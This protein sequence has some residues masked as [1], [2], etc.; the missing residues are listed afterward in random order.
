MANKALVLVSKANFQSRDKQGRLVI[1][2][3]DHV[4]HYLTRSKE[5]TVDV[6]S[7]IESPRL[8]KGNA[9]QSNEKHRRLF[10]LLFLALSFVGFALRASNIGE[11]SI[12]RHLKMAWLH[13]RTTF[14]R[15]VFC[16][17]NPSFLLGIGLSD[18]EL[19]A[20]RELGIRSFEIQHGDFT[21][22]DLDAY[23][24]NHCPDFFLLWGEGNLDIVE[25]FG[26]TPVLIPAP[27]SE[28]IDRSSFEADVLVPLTHS[29]NS[30]Q[31]G[32]IETISK[33]LHRQLEALVNMGL[34]LLIRPHPVFPEKSLSRLEK[35]LTS[36]YSNSALSNASSL[37][38]F[39]SKAPILIVENS[40]IWFDGLRAGSVLL[41]VDS[42]NFERVK[43][44]HPAGENKQ[45]F[46]TPSL[47]ILE[48]TVHSIRSAGFRFKEIDD[49]LG[50]VTWGQWNQLDSHLE[51]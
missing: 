47:K 36:S 38:L 42:D 17:S 26:V 2:K 28:P 13:A 40:S 43:H 1:D 41:I 29:S 45:Y 37:N 34:K 44:L 10:D 33:E 25:S 23:W 51:I 11:S 20:A 31:P 4:I 14:W 35:F 22:S 3:A 7:H 24:P 39:L 19:R 48:Q 12:Q 5:F 16:R 9:Y 6:L 46:F 50:K 18:S 8:P 15:R 49:L 21:A 32:S 27:I 30:P